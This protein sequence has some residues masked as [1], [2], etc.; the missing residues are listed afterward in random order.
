VTGLSGDI[1]LIGDATDPASNWS[2]IVPM[3][4]NSWDHAPP[5]I[6]TSDPPPDGSD[7]ILRDGPGLSFDLTNS[8]IA[9]PDCPS[10]HAP[11]P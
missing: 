11:G 10:N 4:G 3:V 2:G 7:I 8:T 5:S 6:N 9:T 1:W